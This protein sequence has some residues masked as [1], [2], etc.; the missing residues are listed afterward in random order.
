M[1][2]IHGDI[3]GSRL[4]LGSIGNGGVGSL[5]KNKGPDPPYAQDPRWLLVERI[6]ATPDFERSPRLAEFLRHVCRL[7]LEG[8]SKEISEQSLGEVVFGRSPGFDSSADTIVRSHALRL[9]HRLEFYFSSEGTHEPLWVEIP[10]GAYVPRF[11]TPQNEVFA[12]EI[13]VEVEE[14]VD[15]PVSGV[16]V[17]QSSAKAPQRSVSTSLRQVA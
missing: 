8:R 6:L 12:A 2:V 4:K 3:T 17:P 15:A 14:A 16:G 9:R 11:Y 7:T 13:P 10:R 1:D 5:G